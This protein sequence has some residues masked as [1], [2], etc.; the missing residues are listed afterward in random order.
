MPER[1]DAVL[2]VFEPRLDT[3]K[4]CSPMR[5]INATVAWGRRFQPAGLVSNLR[6]GLPCW[7]AWQAVQRGWP[8]TVV[9]ARPQ[10]ERAPSDLQP[11]LYELFFS[12]SERIIADSVFDRDSRVSR[13]PCVTI[14][15]ILGLALPILDPT[16]VLSKH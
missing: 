10:L 13:F 11:H 15:E 9:V 6:P 8:L 2:G 3:L 12:A 4:A 14:R 7:L 16:A 1:V 5:G